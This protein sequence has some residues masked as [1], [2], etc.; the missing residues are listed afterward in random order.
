MPSVRRIQRMT[1]DITNA[2][3]I[4]V[5]VISGQLIMNF[6]LHEYPSIE[7]LLYKM[8]H[9]LSADVSGNPSRGEIQPDGSVRGEKNGYR[10]IHNSERN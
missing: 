2:R 4:F 1:N 3:K 7:M 10:C 8:F 9:L 5:A 6:I